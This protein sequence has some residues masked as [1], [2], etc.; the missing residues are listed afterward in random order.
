MAAAGA[1]VAAGSVA[2]AEGAEDSVAVRPA[3]GFP[4]AGGLLPARAAVV[5]AGGALPA[6]ASIAGRLSALLGVDVRA[7]ESPVGVPAFNPAR[8]LTLASV[9]DLRLAREAGDPESASCRPL[10]SEE[11]IDRGSVPA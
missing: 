4:V 2:A 6:G 1:V 10:A 9:N 5:G 3:A 11:A 8:D 7:A